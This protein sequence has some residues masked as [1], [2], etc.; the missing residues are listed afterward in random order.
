MNEII[1]I[2]SPAIVADRAWDRRENE[3]PKQY[4]A[5]TYYYKLPPADRS[6]AH[7][8]VACYG[9][10][11]DTRSRRSHW[12]KWAKRNRWVDRSFDYDVHLEDLDRI[13]WEKRRRE[14]KEMDFQ[15]GMQLRTLGEKIIAEAENFIKETV[16]ITARSDGG[17]DRTIVRSIDIQAALKLIEL[18]S[19]IQRLSTG[20]STENIKHYR[21]DFLDGLIQDELKKLANGGEAP[22]IEGFEEEEFGDDFDEE[23]AE[24][25]VEE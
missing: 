1:T 6:V 25:T 24:F 4:M 12:L 18:A 22:D 17:I 13:E 3:T 9:P 10:G 16:T 8:I 20:E 11:S 15:Q 19:K 23:D 7:A 5:F 14:V 2:P 21:G